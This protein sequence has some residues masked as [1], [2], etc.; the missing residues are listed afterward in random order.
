MTPAEERSP[1]T[2]S[3]STAR[4]RIAVSVAAAAVTL[5]IGL[6]LTMLAS[7]PSPAAPTGVDGPSAAASVPPTTERVVLVPVAPIEPTGESPARVDGW[8]ASDDGPRARLEHDGEHDDDEEDDD[9]EDEEED[10][11]EDHGRDEEH[12]LAFA[13]D[14]V[15]SD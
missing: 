8:E 13:R 11:D 14:E 4:E 12:R 3:T 10:D 9:E 6:G 2:S 1:A 15:R 7:P 5:A